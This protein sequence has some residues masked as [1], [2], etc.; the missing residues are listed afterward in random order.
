MNSSADSSPPKNLTLPPDLSDRERCAI[1]LFLQ[2]KSLSASLPASFARSSAPLLER[3][4]AISARDRS[5]NAA[6]LKAL[7]NCQTQVSAL[8]EIVQTLVSQVSALEQRLDALG[9]DNAKLTSALESDQSHRKQLLA[10]IH[11]LNAQIRDLKSQ[12]AD[13]NAFVSP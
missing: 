8:H 13:L 12:L 4:N 7:G 2:L 9:Q 1:A 5:E 3:L 10:D 6:L 11:G